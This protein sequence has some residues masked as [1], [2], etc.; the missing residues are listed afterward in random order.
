MTGWV[1]TLDT[2]RGRGPRQGQGQAAGTAQ[3][4]AQA[5]A[6]AQTSSLTQATPSQGAN[7]GMD[8]PQASTTTAARAGE[9]SASCAAQPAA[10][11]A[12]RAGP[13]PAALATRRVPAITV[14]NPYLKYYFYDIADCAEPEDDGPPMPTV[15]VLT[16]R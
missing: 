5:S 8:I 4:Q 13:G 6:Q 10:T 16:T 1:E 12:A 3:A 2:V 9:T 15:S 7:P 11:A 14:N